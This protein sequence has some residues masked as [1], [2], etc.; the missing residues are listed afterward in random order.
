[1]QD[2][3]NGVAG[4]TKDMVDDTAALLDGL[5]KAAV[6]TA[7]VAID[8]T[9]ALFAGWSKASVGEVKKVA[10]AFKVSFR[11]IVQVAADAMNHI[12]SIFSQYYANQYTE[13]DNWYKAQIEALGDM[14]DATQEQLDDKAKIDKEYAERQ[15]E[16]KKQEWETNRGI[17]I[18]NIIISSIEGV[19]KAL[20]AYPP[21]W[22]AI[23]AAVT[24]ALCA[25]QL[26]LVMSQPEPKFATGGDFVVPP[27]YPD[28]SYRMR[29]E[30]GE[31][32]TVT[33][34]GAGEQV[35]HNTLILDGAVL[36]DWYTRGS[37]NGRILTRA[38][39]V[40]P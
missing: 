21:P 19:V 27:G 29:V 13:L 35:I 26:G 37:R 8:D 18:S 32:V 5:G 38:R 25:V 33:P 10:E 31:H 17:T 16:I 2:A 7:K 9:A 36:A 15:S 24:A 28:D 1:V 23:A 40:I 14:T 22:N 34:A 30:S 12:G 6:G 20:A 39:S 3:L 11:D 4:T